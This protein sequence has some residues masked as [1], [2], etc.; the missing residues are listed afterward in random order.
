MWEGYVTAL[1]EFIARYEDVVAELVIDRFHV[2]QHYRAGFDTLRKKEMRRLKEELPDADY[3]A[4]CKGSLWLLRKN[5]ADLDED[6]CAQLKRIFDHTPQLKAAYTLRQELT[7]IFEMKLPR[8]QGKRRLLKW[9]EKVKRSALSC[10]DKFL[11]TL[12]NHLEWIANYFSRRANSGFVEGLN[13]KVKTIK[14]RCY[15]IKKVD[16]LFQ[17]LW[18]DLN[19]YKQFV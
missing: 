4:D 3:D 5:H 12:T 13:N 8:T 2:T 18:L 15:G 11:N 17:R 7:A 9:M 10:F 16:T 14:R 19:G 6:E 1:D